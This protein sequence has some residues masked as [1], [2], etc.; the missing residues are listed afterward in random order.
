[1]RTIHAGK[2][3]E[4][5]SLL[6]MEACYDLPPDVLRAIKCAAD[7]EKS[8]LGKNILNKLIDNAELATRER[9]PYCHDTGLA[10]VFVEMGQD[11]HVVGGSLHEAIQA[12]V[13]KGYKEGYLRKSVV[14]DPLIRENTGDNTPAVVHTEIVEGQS[15]KLTVIPKGGGSENMSSLKFLLPGDGVEGIKQFVLQTV[16][17]AGGKAC[18][19]VVVGVGIGG[20]FDH[21]AYLAKKALLRDIGVYNPKPHLAHLE[22]ELLPLINQSGIGP[23]GLGGVNT[24]L[25]VAVE[26][27]ATHI[28]ALPVAVNLQCHAARKKTTTI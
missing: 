19:P 3:T 1:M 18:P 13:R 17:E 10:V 5:V 8:P 20:T 26:S 14:G 22:K 16:Q 9:M 28:T 27:Y 4:E 2:I 21:V 7:S 11:V 6:C 24:A 15:I 25:W 23:Q 12:G